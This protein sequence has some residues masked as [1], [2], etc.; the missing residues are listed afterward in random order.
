[1]Y[2]ELCLQTSLSTWTYNVLYAQLEILSFD[3]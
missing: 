2:V 3:P 1:M